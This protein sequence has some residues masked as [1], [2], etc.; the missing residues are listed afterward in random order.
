MNVTVYHFLALALA[1]VTGF[2]LCELVCG[3]MG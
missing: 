1:T 2:V 3:S